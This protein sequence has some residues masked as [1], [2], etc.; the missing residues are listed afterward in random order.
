MSES[1][2]A[3]FVE[4]VIKN[5]DS[6]IVG[7]GRWQEVGDEFGC[8]INSFVTIGFDGH[9][10]E[11]RVKL[12]IVF[13]DGKHELRGEGCAATEKTDKERVLVFVAGDDFLGEFVDALGYL[14]AGVESGVGGHGG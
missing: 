6:S 11:F 1:S 2:G 9:V 14:G 12:G 3:T 13:G 5:N 8:A 4:Y 7:R 10:V